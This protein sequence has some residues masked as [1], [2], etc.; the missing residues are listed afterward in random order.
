MDRFDLRAEL[1]HALRPRKLNTRAKPPTFQCTRHDDKTP[2]AWIG[3]NA[4]GCHACGFTESLVTLAEALD[5]PVPRKG[6]T[7]EDYAER[8]G[9]TLDNLTR[10]GVRTVEGKYGD[11]LLAIPYRDASGTLLRTKHRTASKSFWAEDGTGVHLY[12]LDALA[13]YPLDEPVIL[14]E[15]ESDCHAAWSHGVLA[16]GLPGASVWRSEWG[17][18]L[19]GRIVYI[20]QEPDE[21]GAKMTARLAEDLP[22]A[23]VIAAD[24]VKD[25]AELHK[26]LGKGFKSAIR[27]RM[28]TAIP[29]GKTPPTTPYDVILGDT[30]DRLLAEKLAPVDAVPTPFAT[31][32]SRCRDAGGGIGLARG[33]HLTIGG[34]T[35]NGKSLLAL[36]LAASAVRHGERVAFHSL[37]MSQ[38]QLSTRWLAIMSGVSVAKLEQGHAFDLPS[39]RYATEEMGRVYAER[40]G[41]LSV[42]RARLSK[43]DDIVTAMRWQYE[44]HGCLYHIVDYL[45]LAG[46]SERKSEYDRVQEVSHTVRNTAVSLGVISVALSQ[47]NRETSKNYD[48]PPTPQGL[49]G[50]SALE[51]DSDQVA[52]LDHSEYHRD[53]LMNT[54]RTRLLLAKN[55]HG[56]LA[57]I[58]VLWRYRDLTITEVTTREQPTPAPA[59]TPPP[60]SGEAWEPETQADISFP[61]HDDREAA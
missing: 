21:A 10:W 42:N 28:E 40:G 13:K 11:D 19:T 56:A 23:R 58:D 61:Q 6:F 27:A 12:G 9:F 22:E 51:N 18:H 60:N 29:I 25:V 30:L 8:K 34:N 15:G 31:W 53:D 36:N 16:V 52:L 49:H 14:V 54:A 45:Q 26:T 3:D 39:W 55:R 17:Q 57:I 47:F 32:N 46:T 44:V 20:W 1:L 48:G 59:I 2:S 43:L 5:V 35:G 24:G 38:T 37:E 4:W 50:G 33:W 41:V 7:V